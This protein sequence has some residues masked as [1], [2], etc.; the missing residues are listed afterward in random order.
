MAVA[1]AK[2]TNQRRTY[3]VN[4]T[5]KERTWDVTLTGSYATGGESITPA[6]V[7]L[8]EISRVNG[9]VTEAS[10][11]TTEWVPYWDQTNNKVKLFGAGTGATGLTEHAAAAYA[12]S[13]AG[14]ITFVG[15]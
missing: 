8:K 10:G 9:Y 1:V 13:T 14:R 15:V 11:A 12:A 2:P 5:L 6:S 7:G 4:G 3:N